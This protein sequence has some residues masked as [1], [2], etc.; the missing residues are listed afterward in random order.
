MSLGHQDHERPPARGYEREV[1]YPIS[2][3]RRVRVSIPLARA[4]ITSITTANVG[5]AFTT[6]PKG[7]SLKSNG[8][9]F[10]N[11]PSF[12]KYIEREKSREDLLVSKVEAEWAAIEREFEKEVEG[13]KK[14]Y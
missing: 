1:M 7:R 2:L 14:G 3:T 13:R 11:R 6:S 5:I 8:K 12:I 10:K 4:A 9:T